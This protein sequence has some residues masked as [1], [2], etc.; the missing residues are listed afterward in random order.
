MTTRRNLSISIPKFILDDNP[1]CAE[2]DPEL[3]FPQEGLDFSG[4]NI[5]KY[6]NLSAAKKICESCPLKIPCLQYALENT[7]I[8]VWGGT[9][10]EQRNLLRKKIGA[11]RR[12]RKS[13]SPELW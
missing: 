7:E 4:K 1:A 13:P 12:Q 9:T 5:S 2:T 8:G 3:F 6:V 11:T 10:E